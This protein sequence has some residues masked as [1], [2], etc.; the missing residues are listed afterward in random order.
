MKSFD[1]VRAGGI[2]EAVAL[3]NAPGLTS[4]ALAGGTD[5]MVMVRAGEVTFDRVVDIS[6][7]ADMRRIWIDGTR[8]HIGAAVTFSELMRHPLVLRHARFLA[9]AAQSVRTMQ[10]ENM[11]T[12]GGNVA[13]A[14]AAADTPPVLV[15]LDAQAVIATPGGRKRAPV[16][17]LLRG[18]LTNALPP[19]ALICGF[20][21][22]ALPASARS[23][24]LKLGRRNALTISRINIA[25]VGRMGGDGRIDEAR[26]VAGACFPRPRR[27]REVE[28]MLRGQPPSAELFRSAGQMMARLMVE[29]SGRRWSTDY[30]SRALAAMV[31]EALET[32]LPPVMPAPDAEHVGEEAGQV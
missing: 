22:E 19:G 31:E 8:L 30:K 10:I 21:F 3:L 9:D 13:N 17:D 18:H 7:V 24:F 14:A 28:A 20:E 11:A 27:A 1:Y 25:A 5:L 6:G 32:V 16:A 2:D 12:L 23:V 15:C 26:L 4:R 29:E